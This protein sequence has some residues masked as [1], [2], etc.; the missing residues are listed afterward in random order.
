MWGVRVIHKHRLKNNKPVKKIKIKLSQLQ[1]NKYYCLQL[2][3]L[4]VHWESI[5]IDEPWH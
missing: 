1:N 2:S 5:Y 3:T 4:K